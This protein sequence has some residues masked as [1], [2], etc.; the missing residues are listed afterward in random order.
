MNQPKSLKDPHNVS[1]LWCN[2]LFLLA[3]QSGYGQVKQQSCTTVPSEF[4]LSPIQTIS[5]WSHKR[6][7]L[8]A[9]QKLPLASRLGPDG[10]EVLS[11]S[12]WSLL[13]HCSLFQM[14][15]CRSRLQ[16]SSGTIHPTLDTAAILQLW[17]H[18]CIENT[19]VRAWS[20]ARL[21]AATTGVVSYF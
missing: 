15:N 8:T 9:L 6:E 7:L 1:V 19:S 17:S 4:S 10:A 21:E 3:F 11:D 13:H 20:S 16:T 5:A 14:E 12:E 18:R 2:L